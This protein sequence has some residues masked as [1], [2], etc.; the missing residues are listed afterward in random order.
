MIAALRFL[1]LSDIHFNASSGATV[2][3][4]DADVRNELVR[5]ATALSKAIGSPAGVLVTGDV[6]FSGQCAEYE[7]AASWLLEFCRAVGCPEENVWVVPGN[8][9]SLWR[10]WC[11]GL[12]AR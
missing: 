3:D 11:H 2:H 1:H 9:S 7:R 4:L 6:A 12:L 10:S 5:D 8:T